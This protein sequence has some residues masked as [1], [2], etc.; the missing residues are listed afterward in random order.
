MS[1]TPLKSVLVCAVLAIAVFACFASSLRNGFADYDD[2]EYVTDNPHV[3]TGINGEN[4]KWALTAAHSNN[5]HPLTWI[6]HAVDATLFGLDP[7]GHH[8]TSLI[9]HV[10]NTLLLFAWLYGA[11]GRQMRSAFVALAFGLHPLHVESVAWVAERKDVLSTF[12]WMLTLLAYSAYVKRPG[13]ARYFLAAGCLAAGLM[14]KQMLV[15]VPVLLLVLDGWPLKR[16][17]R[18]GRLVLEKVPLLFLSGLACAA[19]LWAQRRGG[20]VAGIEQLPLELRLAN[21]ALSYIRYAAMTVWPDGLAVFYPFPLHGIAAWKVA[22]AVAALAGVSILVF[23]LRRTRPWLTVG[24]CWYVITLLPVIGIVQVGMQA[25]ADRYMY[26][27]MIGLSIAVAW[28]F[29]RRAAVPAVAVLAVWGVVSWRQTAVWKDGVTLFTHAIAVTDDNFLAHDNLGVLL[30]RRGRFDEALAHYRE[31][32][33]IKPGDRQGETNLAQASFA[34][35]VRLQAQGK[36]DEAIAAFREGLRYRPGNAPAN[37]ALAVALAGVGRAGEARWAFE[38]TLRYDP[39]NVEAHYDL[40]LILAGSGKMSEALPHFEAASR[41]KPE[42]GPAHVALAE[43][44]YAAGRFAESWREVQAAR[45][46]HAAIDP[47]LVSLLAPHITH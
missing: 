3:R 34:R 35:G 33:R 11:T 37:M 45:A 19:A 32:L 13:I 8:L 40:G 43:M 9:L 36:P 46:A 15:T 20:A 2:N 31:T 41:L 17:D 10:I 7:A 14:A 16:G 28:E 22:G 42:F 21:G 39:E 1:S 47:E 4:A 12:F 18:W 26:V 29:D 25:M 24:W 27:P 44:Y 5:W 38:D 23:R 6:S 30:D